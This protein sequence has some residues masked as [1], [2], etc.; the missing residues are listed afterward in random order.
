MAIKFFNIHSG[1]EREVDTEPMIA[2]FYNSTNLHINAMVGQDFGWRI[3][4][5]TIERI[6]AIK[7]DEAVLLRIASKFNL[8]LDG[9]SDTDILHW[10]SI[11]DA[12]AKESNSEAGQNNYA[13]EYEDRIRAIRDK[14]DGRSTDKPKRGRPSTKI[15]D[16][17]EASDQDD[18]EVESDSNSNDSQEA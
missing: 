13:R 2:A 9:I 14:K 11:E 18:S 5:E 15:A 8:L 3:A 12:K 10:I 1:E 6:E 7:S 4:P 16:S 17:L